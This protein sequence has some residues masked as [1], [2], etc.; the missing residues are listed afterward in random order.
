MSQEI[1]NTNTNSDKTASKAD[2]QSSTS[3]AKFTPKR[4][5]A[6]IGMV[7]LISLYVITLL[8]SIFDKSSDGKWVMISI[9]ATF[10]IPFLLWIYIW[11]YG[12]MTGKKTIADFNYNIG[13]NKT[14]E[15]NEDEN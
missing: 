10:A 4:I 8:V 9:G 15:E 2:E 3:S 6:I 5:A 7:L 11:I 12:Q 14:E 1:K 13:P